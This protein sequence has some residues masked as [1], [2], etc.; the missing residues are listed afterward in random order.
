MS[1]MVEVCWRVINKDTCDGTQVRSC[2][3]MPQNTECQNLAATF[4]QGPFQAQMA[5]W[6]T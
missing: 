3:L 2:L 5:G 1:L 4:L 6:S